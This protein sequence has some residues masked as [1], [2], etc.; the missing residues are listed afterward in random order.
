M[1]ARNCICVL[2]GGIIKNTQKYLYNASPTDSKEFP[3]TFSPSVVPLGIY[4]SNFYASVCTDRVVVYAD[5]IFI[6]GA[7]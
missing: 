7:D 4:I 5:I 2:A 6:D 3:D 1:Q